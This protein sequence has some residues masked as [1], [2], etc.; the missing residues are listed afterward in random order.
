MNHI[1]VAL[2]EGLTVEGALGIAFA[3]WRRGGYIAHKLSMSSDGFSRAELMLLVASS[4]EVVRNK[5]LQSEKP[6]EKI[7]EI[8]FIYEKLFCLI[9]LVETTTGSFLLLVL[10]SEK[11]NLSHAR[12]KLSQISSKLK[13]PNDSE[14]ACYQDQ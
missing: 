11:G 10:D 2:G 4:T 6:A 13:L 7:R 3:D 12:L 9:R 1:Q 14:P 5:A 8:V